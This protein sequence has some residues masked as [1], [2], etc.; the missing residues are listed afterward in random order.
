MRSFPHGFDYQTDQAIGDGITDQ[1]FVEANRVMH[2]HDR[3]GA[4]QADKRPN[5]SHVLDGRWKSCCG[6]KTPKGREYK[7]DKRPHR[8]SVFHENS[9]HPDCK[10]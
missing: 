6:E 8:N 2:A 4:G 1:S 5:I 10:L 9:G 7:A 3:N